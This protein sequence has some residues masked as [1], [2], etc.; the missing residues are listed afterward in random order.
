MYIHTYI[1]FF[2]HL[3]EIVHCSTKG[4]RD[5]P[6]YLS[7]FFLVPEFYCLIYFKIKFKSGFNFW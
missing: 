7:T 6:D 1:C 5:E 4:Q 2:K 3:C